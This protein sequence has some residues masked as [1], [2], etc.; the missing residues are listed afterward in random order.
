[1]AIEFT[2]LG[3]LLIIFKYL[4]FSFL[5]SIKKVVKNVSMTY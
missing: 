2:V 1:M 5:K 4:I 3:I